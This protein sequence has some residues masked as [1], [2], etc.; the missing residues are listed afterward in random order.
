MQNQTNKTISTQL[1]CVLAFKFNVDDFLDYPGDP[2]E[3]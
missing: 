1:I 3:N 2:T